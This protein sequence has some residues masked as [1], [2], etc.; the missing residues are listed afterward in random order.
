MPSIMMILV[1]TMRPRAMTSE[2]SESV[3]KVMPCHSITVIATRKMI[4]SDRP[5]MI[6]WRRPSARNRIKV[7][8]SAVC[9]PFLV[10]LS[11]SSFMKRELSLLTVTSMS[12]GMMVSLSSSILSFA[13]FAIFVMLVSS[14]L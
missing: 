12:F 3:F 5:A 2:N 10:S 11:N 4:G 1:S 9:K 8:I 14:F 7:I 6:P 13:L